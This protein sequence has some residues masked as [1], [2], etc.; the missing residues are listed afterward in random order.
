MTGGRLAGKVALVMS[1]GTR[2]GRATA[3]RFA[4]EGAR[5]AVA[6]WRADAALRESR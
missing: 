6:D 2:I 1:A 3:H 5:V 4:D